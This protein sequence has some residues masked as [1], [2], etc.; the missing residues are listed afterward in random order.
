MRGS[1]AEFN[2]DRA[3]CFPPRPAAFRCGNESLDRYIREQAGQD[4]RRETA[5]VFVAV[6][7]DRPE[8]IFGFFTLSAATVAPSDLPQA[9]AKHL[10]RHPIPA[11]LIGRLAVDTTAKRR[12]LGSVLLADA[13]KKAA[14]AVEAVAMLVIVVDPIDDIARNFY[15]AFGFRSL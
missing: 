7:S 3:A 1:S 8:N 6:I 14:V 2:P 9:M 10:P 15:S 13:Y 4:L 11:A 5:R 12:G